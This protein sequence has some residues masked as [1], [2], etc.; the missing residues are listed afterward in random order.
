MLLRSILDSPP[1]IILKHGD[2]TAG[3]LYQH[4]QTS[5]SAPTPQKIHQNPNSSWNRSSCARRF[6]RS[7]L[8]PGWTS[9]PA[10]SML[11]C[12]R[13]ST[14]AKSRWNLGTLLEGGSVW[15]SHLI[16]QSLDSV[17]FQSLLSYSEFPFFFLVFQFQTFFWELLWPVAS[18]WHG[19][20]TVAK[21]QSGRSG[22]EKCHGRYFSKMAQIKPYIYISHIYIYIY[23]H[24]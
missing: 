7:S 22:Q 18:N 11:P 20:T 5:R 4:D 9:T 15:F 3:D 10:R 16:T 1:C 8:S 19:S 12:S 24:I 14:G 13:G 6:A 21:A 23:I 17:R 2:V